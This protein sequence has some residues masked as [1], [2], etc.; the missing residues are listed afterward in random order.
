MFRDPP[1]HPAPR[2][3]NEGRQKNTGHDR[4]PI[5]INFPS[6]STLYNPCSRRFACC[7]DISAVDLSGKFGDDAAI[8]QSP[9]VGICTA[10]INTRKFTFCPR[11]AFAHYAKSLN[12]SG[13]FPIQ[14]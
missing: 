10:K 5:L 7:P 14:H 8:F 1:P 11:T 12:K 4:H 6:H 9:V 2:F 13:C 3:R